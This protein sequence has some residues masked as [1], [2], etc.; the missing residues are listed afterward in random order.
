MNRFRLGSAPELSA[1]TSR[2]VRGAVVRTRRSLEDYRIEI[3]GALTPARR[4]RLVAALEKALD[5]GAPQVVL[6]LTNVEAIDRD[7]TRAILLAHLRAGDQRQEL[8]IVTGRDSVRAAFEAI[9]GP[10]QF[11]DDPLDH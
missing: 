9:A 2:P 8:I 11:A 3:S 5:V 6:D 7:C 1:D 10:F 4:D